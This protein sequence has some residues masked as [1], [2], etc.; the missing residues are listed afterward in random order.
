MGTE[1]RLLTVHAHA[2][3][4][5][6]TMGPTL[7]VLADQGVATCL[8]TCTDGELATVYATDMVEE[9][10]RPRLGEIRRDELRAAA[11]ALG[12]TELHFLGYHDSGMAGA[13]TNQAPHAFWRADMED[14]IGRLVERIRAFRPQVVVTYDAYGGYGHP[15]H[16]QAHRGT[17]LAIEAA[18]RPGM[19]PQAGEPWRVSKLY[20]TAFPL[21]LIRKA[22]AMA[23]AAGLP[24]PFG[25]QAPEEMEGI[26]PD[27][28]VTTRVE[29]RSGSARRR[30]ALLAHHSQIALDFPLVA[31]P[32][33]V[34]AE[35]FST[36]NYQ[37][38]W[39]RVPTTVPEADLFA[40]LR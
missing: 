34:M 11:S 15:D 1:L 13:D 16:I 3:D 35:H 17:V 37:L 14:V 39:S 2:D 25:E 9:E 24:P 10:V 40:G 12:V 32:E 33:E 28:V 19:F 30:A 36:D 8:V 5:T 4:E 21:S 20:Y 26:V 18:A 38:A 23:E 22:V 27:E 7:A 6:L 31:I 29:A